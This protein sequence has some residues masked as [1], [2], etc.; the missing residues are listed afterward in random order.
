MEKT[1]KNHDMRNIWKTSLRLIFSGN[2]DLPLKKCFK[3]C[4]MMR[5]YKEIKK[6]LSARCKLSGNMKDCEG[7]TQ[8][9][10]RGQNRNLVTH[11]FGSTAYV[12]LAYRLFRVHS[13]F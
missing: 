12:D 9:L 11:F 13:L 10:R 4:S 3:G 5:P 8:F 7:V 1:S 2:P 6:S